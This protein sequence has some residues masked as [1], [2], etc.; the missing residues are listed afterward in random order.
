MP[1]NEPPRPVLSQAEATRRMTLLTDL[2]DALAARGIR[3]V[4]AKRRRLVLRSS[5]PVTPSGPL[6]PQLHIFHPGRAPT[7]PPP[8]ATPTGSPAAANTQPAI[9]A[10]GQPV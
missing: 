3:A 2:Q 6:D 10:Q 4:L 8:T 7:S 5:Q 9:P 1:D